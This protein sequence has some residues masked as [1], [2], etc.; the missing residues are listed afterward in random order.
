M[1]SIRAQHEDHRVN[2]AQITQYYTGQFRIMNQSRE[3]RC[4]ER[5]YTPL[6]HEF[7]RGLFNSLFPLTYPLQNYR[8][9]R[10]RDQ[11]N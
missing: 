6:K 10:K 7:H 4:T 9:K 1:V 11:R 3:F 8:R 5:K 2:N